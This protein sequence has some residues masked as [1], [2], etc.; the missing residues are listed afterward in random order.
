MLKKRYASVL[1][2][3]FCL[4]ATFFITIMPGALCVQP[5][6]SPWPPEEEWHPM[7]PEEA[8]PEIGIMIVIYGGEYYLEPSQPFY[9]WYRWGFVPTNIAY[10]LSNGE[11]VT[12]I[13]SLQDRTD[14][15]NCRYTVTM[16]G[17]PLKPTGNFTATCTWYRFLNGDYWAVAPRFVVHEHYIEFPQG[18]KADDYSI[19]LHGQPS[20]G[21]PIDLWTTLH[22]APE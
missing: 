19:H 5:P 10:D 3:I 2:L 15:A 12:P 1:A 22:V 21:E 9:L 20:G 16:N 13:W 17:E 6:P 14:Y 4:T 11:P 18:L 8:R 7:S